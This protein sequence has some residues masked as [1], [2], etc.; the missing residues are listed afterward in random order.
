VRRGTDVLGLL[1]GQLP[2]EGLEAG[3]DTSVPAMPEEGATDHA[4]LVALDKAGSTAEFVALQ[5][6]M[7]TGQVLA[8]L[9]AMVLDGRVAQRPG[10]RFFRT[11]SP[12][13]EPY[14]TRGT[15]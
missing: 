2:G 6:G 3:R 7:E 15:V 4:V 10:G 11:S 5:T 9:M 8:V 12:G 1:S 13:R 14:D